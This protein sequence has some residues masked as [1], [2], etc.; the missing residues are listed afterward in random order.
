M[1]TI[2][3]SQS[4]QVVTFVTHKIFANWPD[5]SAGRKVPFV[6]DRHRKSLFPNGSRHSAP[7]RSLAAS[8]DWRRA[9]GGR[10][11][12][13][14]EW[15]SLGFNLH[16][17]L[18][19]I[20]YRG[21]PFLWFTSYAGS[22]G[23][24][25]LYYER[26]CFSRVNPNAYRCRVVIDQISRTINNLVSVILAMRIDGWT[27]DFQQKAFWLFVSITISQWT[28]RNFLTIKVR[29]RREVGGRR[30]F[31]PEIRNYRFVI[32]IANLGVICFVKSFRE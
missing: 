27:I 23:W 11:K 10:K 29:T 4:C 21:F 6:V 31:H 22:T 13:G 1:P 9:A 26:G 2:L 16:S 25:Y 3:D 18:I 7:S 19:P 12:R 30:N 14:K 8:H 28:R 24:Y 15:E 17:I 5:I 20:R 32:F